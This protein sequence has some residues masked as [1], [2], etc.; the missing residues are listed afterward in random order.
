M[1]EIED[2]ELTEDPLTNIKLMIPLLNDE[3][4]RAM[5]Y[6]MYGCYLGETIAEVKQEKQDKEAQAV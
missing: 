3:S 5:S 1:A 4:R 2:L 6:L